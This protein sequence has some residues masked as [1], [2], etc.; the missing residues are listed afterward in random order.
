[1]AGGESSLFIDL[2]LKLGS[3]RGGG[4]FGWRG[5]GFA[6]SLVA[7]V[8]D[9]AALKEAFFFEEHPVVPEVAGGVTHGMIILALDEG[10]LFGEGF[11]LLS[12]GV[13]FAGF[14]G[15]IHRGEKVDVGLLFGALVVDGILNRGFLFDPFG[16]LLEA[17]AIACLV[18]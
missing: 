10:A 1:M 18:A 16:A 7:P 17:D 3:R 5:L 14:K 13:F 2:A 6:Q 9:G 15:S 12:A 11:F 8:P 4:K